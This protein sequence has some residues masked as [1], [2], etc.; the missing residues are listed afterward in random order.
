MSQ[1]QWAKLADFVQYAR[2][3]D[4]EQWTF[5][6]ASLQIRTHF[7]EM[8]KLMLVDSFGNYLQLKTVDNTTF[9]IQ[10]R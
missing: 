5:H 1:L 9:E 7:R 8:V 10:E 6:P 2:Q 4:E 3:V